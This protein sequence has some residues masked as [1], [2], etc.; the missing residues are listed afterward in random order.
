[1]PWRQVAF[2]T[3]D[4]DVNPADGASEPEAWRKGSW[5]KKVPTGTAKMEIPVHRSAVT[6]QGDKRGYAAAMS[7][8]L[9]RI[10]RRMSSGST[11][12]LNSRRTSAC[13]TAV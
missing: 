2:G 9:A 1:M 10:N 6:E 5:G 4:R 3:Y 13:P 7:S 11:A 8:S 12:C